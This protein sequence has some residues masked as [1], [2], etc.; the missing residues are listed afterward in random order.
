MAIESVVEYEGCRFSI[1]DFVI[2]PQFE[3]FSLS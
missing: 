2:H 1:N 3:K